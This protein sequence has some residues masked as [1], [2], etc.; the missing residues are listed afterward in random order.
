[1]RNPKVDKTDKRYY[2]IYGRYPNSFE[3]IK[4]ENEEL[5]EEQEEY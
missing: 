2:D 3:R 4:F 5:D 1:M